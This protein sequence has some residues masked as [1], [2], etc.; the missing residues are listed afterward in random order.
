MADRINEEIIEMKF[1]GDPFTM[2][3]NEL[4]L[5]SDINPNTRL[6]YG[7]IKRYITIPGFVLY[8]STL[9]KALGCGSNNTFDKYWKDL[10][11]LGLLEQKRVRKKTGRW[12]YEY[13]LRSTYVQQQGKKEP[14][15]KK[16]GMEEPHPK[17]WGTENMGSQK[18]GVSN[19]NDFNNNELNNINKDLD[20]KDNEFYNYFEKQSNDIDIHES[21]PESFYLIKLTEQQEKDV[22]RLI[23]DIG[24]HKLNSTKEDLFK[25]IIRL[26]KNNFKDHNGKSIK[27]LYATVSS[28]FKNKTKKDEQDKEWLKKKAEDGDP[29]A[30]EALDNIYY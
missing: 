10:K 1:E 4:L 20:L 24:T 12:G 28:A 17:K 29:Y 3:P 21:N 13:I 19:N 2:I 9:R 16:W 5:D 30:A 6:L 8:K 23:I 25:Y 22:N 26:Y 18:V 27:S 11:T 7:I 14:H 15:P